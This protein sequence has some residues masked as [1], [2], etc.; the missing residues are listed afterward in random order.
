MVKGQGGLE[1]ESKDEEEEEEV[2]SS[3]LHVGNLDIIL[4]APWT[5]QSL[6][7]CLGV[8][9][10]DSGYGSCV[11]LRWHMDISHIFYVY[12]DSTLDIDDFRWFF[13]LAP[14]YHLFSVCLARGKQEK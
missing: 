8:A 14:W 3:L 2:P 7:R 11:S 13:L 1:E 6:V 12:A 4:R 10:C 5:W 9:W